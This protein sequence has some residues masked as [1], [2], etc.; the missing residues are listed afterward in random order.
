MILSQIDEPEGVSIVVPVKGWLNL[1]EQLLE[2]IHATTDSTVRERCEVVLVWDGEPSPVPLTES[3]ASHHGL[4]VWC[5]HCNDHPAAKRNLGATK[6]RYSILLFVDSDCQ[7]HPDLLHALMI[8]FQQPSVMAAAP[9]IHFEPARTIL[10]TANAVMPYRQAYNWGSIP[11]PQWWAPTATLAVRRRAMEQVGP[12]WAPSW[13]PIR[14]E[15][16]DWGLRLTAVLGRPSIKTLSE[17]PTRHALETWGNLGQIL[18]RAWWFGWSEGDL[19]PRHPRFQRWSLPPFLASANLILL[20][21][22][23][24]AVVQFPTS[25][26]LAMIGALL[27]LIWFILEIRRLLAAG[28]PLRAVPAGLLLAAAF[29]LARTVSLWVSKNLTGGIWF[30]EHQAKGSWLEFALAGWLVWVA[31]VITILL[32]FVVY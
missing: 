28:L 31:G 14:G 9:P 4:N 23:L 20:I 2:S 3:F 30:H 8:V 11:E 15:D 18:K 27:A 5:V 26:G 32:L 12:F 24:L 25:L 21:A 17:Y 19:R 29:D 16:V 6:A 22:V 7:I 10:E 1:L 13:G